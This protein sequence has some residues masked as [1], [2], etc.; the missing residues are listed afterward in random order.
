[1]PF[2]SSFLSKKALEALSRVGVGDGATVG[3]VVRNVPSA[4]K[5][6]FSPLVQ[7]ITGGPERPNVL[8]RTLSPALNFLSPSRQ[9][10]LEDIQQQRQQTLVPSFARS[11]ILKREKE[12]FQ[13]R[14]PTIRQSGESEADFQKRF[15]AQ[16][17]IDPFAVGATKRVPVLLSTT[18]KK[19]AKETSAEV[20]DKV[21]KKEAPELSTTLRNKV[22]PRIVK[23]KSPQT[24]EREFSKVAQQS[25]GITKKA[26]TTKTPQP[27]EKEAQDFIR[28]NPNATAEEFVEAQPKVFHGTNK[29]FDKFDVSKISSN[30]KTEGFFGKGFYFTKNQEQAKKFAERGVSQEGG[31]VNIKELFLDYKN[32]FIIDESTS[33]KQIQKLTETT[34]GIEGINGATNADN[35]L[36]IITENPSKFT[37]NLKKLGHDGVEV[38][39]G[40]DGLRDEFM[41][42]SP[43][44]IKTKSQITDIFNRAKGTA[45]KVT[46]NLTQQ[47]QDFIKKNPKGTAEEFEESQR[48]VFHQTSPENAIKIEKE[49]FRVDVQGSGASD[50]LPIGVNTKSTTKE[51]LI[52]GSGAQVEAFL[53]IEAKIKTFATRNE[54]ERFFRNE[55]KIFREADDNV[56]KIDKDIAKRA[57][58]IL[59]RPTKGKTRAEVLK[60]TRDAESILIKGRPEMLRQAKI[61]KE[62][63][64]RIMKEQGFDAIEIK[65]DIGGFGETDNLIVLDPRILKTKS[66]LKEAFNKAKSGV[67]KTS[68]ETKIQ[69]KA[70]SQPKPQSEKP[71][72]DNRVEG[73]VPKETSKS[74]V[75]DSIKDGYNEVFLP[76]QTKFQTFRKNVEDYNIRLKEVNNKISDLLG[77]KEIADH[78]DIYARKDMLPR[79]TSDA[80]E[81]VR[82]Q[83]ESFVHELVDKDI[84]TD[85][86]DRY[87]IARH[88]AERNAKMKEVSGR[89]VDGL[90][91]MKDADAK[92][93]LQ[94]APEELTAFAKKLDKILDDN[95]KFQVDKGLITQKEADMLKGAYKNY[96]PLYRDVDDSFTGIGMGTDIRGKE[97]KRAFGS[98]K[99]VTSPIANIFYQVEK[100]HVRALKNEVGKTVQS[101]VKEHPDL[102]SLF[103]IT[104]QQYTPRY[105][106][107][108]EI[109][110]MD[111]KFKMADNVVGFKENGKQMFIE[112]ADKEVAAA[113]KNADLVQ[114]PRF[115]QPL[116]TAVAIWSSMKTRWSPEFLITNFERDL[117][118]ALINLGVE[119]EI[120][121]KAGKGLRRAVVKDLFPSQNAIRKHLKYQR[122]NGKKGKLDSTFDE[123]LERGGDTGHFWVET[124]KKGEE[125]LHALEKRLKG[126]GKDGVLNWGR[127]GLKL[128]DDINSVVELGVRFSTYKALVKKGMSK[129][130]AIQAAAD[131]TINFSRQGAYA[132]I[133]KSLYGFINPTVQGSSK[134]LRA[135]GHG[136]GRKL[137]RNRVAM[138]A[139]G[140]AL[141]G[142]INRQMSMAL[143]PEG[144]EAIPE[145]SKN[146]KLVVSIGDGKSITLWNMPYGF[147]LFSA[148]GSN[149]A[150]VQAGKKTFGEGMGEVGKTALTSFSPFEGDLY[151]LIPTMMKPVVEATSNHAWYDGP[152]YP[153]QKFTRTP[154]A[155]SEVAFKNTS[156]TYIGIAKFLN[157]ITGGSEGKAGLLDFH[158]E[159]L[160]YV[161][162]QYIGGPVTFAQQSL[163]AIGRGA[164]GEFN[165]SKTPFVKKFYRKDEPKGFVYGTI[166]DTLERSLKKDLSELEINRFYRAV[167]TGLNKEIISQDYADSV[168]K[169]F[170]KAR[171]GV[172]GSIT[173]E[174]NKTKLQRM[175][176]VDRDRLIETYSE[177]TQKKLNRESNVEST[178]PTSKYQSFRQRII[179]GVSSGKIT[180]ER[181]IELLKEAK[182]I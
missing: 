164:T 60:E 117:S 38:K 179:D 105:D 85:D 55:S 92:K 67:S 62:E 114:L 22:V 173:S 127:D 89:D 145:Y 1:M 168:V 3:D 147:A 144:D 95:L 12:N 166:S 61:A 64:T 4:T 135:L 73:I 156:Q 131:L 142:Y 91:G 134:V 17:D 74:S 176:E 68:P 165:P 66:Q 108:G 87:M 65:R 34:K 140:L 33:L 49:G 59:D 146:H 32:P 84:K 5:D 109:T 104:K 160:N 141:L 110:R 10:I 46:D 52:K 124:A 100:A 81:R 24:V 40:G 148:L 120:L 152:I 163:E 20:I 19:L 151:S 28:K 13:F 56:N 174:E 14:P 71:K 159:S 111:P 50:T 15:L 45:P 82:K 41:V 79:K 44:Q 69:R 175:N 170:I 149:L 125:S 129:D 98:Q 169:E 180:E 9:K 171:Y 138:G 153:K 102:K 118:E 126:E 21:L 94:E 136:E 80:I 137:Y 72:V 119:K 76:D 103:K 107:N 51:L 57:E 77:T 115:M 93:I 128:V 27:L 143:D 6:L 155:D 178:K 70:K 36:F 75:N 121:G 29:Q 122:T 150:E 139:T 63:A 181:G 30:T 90:S 23:A 172:S 8:N 11:E 132:P 161:F 112:V 116:R 130:K 58:E 43:E 35:L 39:F 162:D 31:L 106:K 18:L 42:F 53:P 99:R 96:V 86:L 78:L 16:K 47:A 101:I 154:K 113:L 157:K 7:D 2:F 177:S 97:S 133:A 123:F 158:P 83:R 26:P 54:A 167:D 25:L 37:E 48:K 182:S 88:A